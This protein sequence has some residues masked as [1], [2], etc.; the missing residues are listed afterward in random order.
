MLSPRF[1]PSKLLGEIIFEDESLI[2]I[3]KPAGKSSEDCVL[4]MQIFENV[5]R[6]SGRRAVED[7]AICILSLIKKT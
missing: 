2:A 4:A 6:Y 7:D 3:A 1:Q 5:G